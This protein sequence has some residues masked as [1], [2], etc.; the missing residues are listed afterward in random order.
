MYFTEHNAAR[1]DYFRNQIELWWQDSL[2]SLDEYRYLLACLIE[3]V[4]SV[5]NTAGVYGA[6]LKKWDSR[7][8]KSILLNKFNL[9]SASYSNLITYNSKL[10]DVIESIE[11]DILY[12]DPP[13]TQNQYGTQYHILE[14][15]I[16]NDHPVISRVTGSRSTAPMRSDWS[17]KYKANILLDKILSKTNAKYVILS[18]NNDGIMSKEFIEASMKRYG[19]PDTFLC[20]Q[21]MYKKYQNWKSSN[22]REHFEY[23]FF[24]ELEEKNNVQYESPLNYIGSKARIVKNIKENAPSKFTKF[25]DA[26][27]GGF[28]VGI[29]FNVPVMIYNDIN[30]LVKRLVESFRKEDTYE[31]LLYMDKNIRKF[32]LEQANSETYFKARNYYN[33]IPHSKQDIR[34]LFLIILYGY[35][36]QIRFN[37]KYEFNNPV[38]MRWFNEKVLEKMISFSRVIKE[39]DYVFFSKNYT[40][41]EP[42]VDNNTFVYIDPP[43]QLTLG[44]YN[45]GKRGFLGWNSQS[46]EA[47]FSFL[48]NLTSKKIPF[49]LSYVIEHKG[50]I[51]NNL[52]AWVKNNQYNVIELGDIIGISGSRRKEV[53]ITNYD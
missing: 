49:M 10:E 39:R 42:Y 14:T 33:S 41:L 8:L 24:I 35:Q 52:I 2:L 25:I 31:Y 27:G 46:E 29:N 37:S 5:S 9:D 18:Y 6:Y 12:L 22:Q 17:K 38:G 28:N 51:N 20:K 11:C 48:N 1:I 21:I 7:A 19:K 26:F 40:E 4:S 36:Q 16:L 13:Y 23:L 30:F 50:K 32:G 43:Y 47:L 45:D 53:L 3:S 15:L 34:L 44:T